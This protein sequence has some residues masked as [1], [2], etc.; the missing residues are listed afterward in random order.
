MQDENEDFKD[1]FEIE[2]VKPADIVV[3]DAPTEDG[4]SYDVEAARQNVHHLLQ[5]GTVALDE[6][7]SVARSSQSIAGFDAVT[8]ML[9]TLSNINK[10]LIVIQEKK[11]QMK[12]ADVTKGKPDKVVQNNLYVGS[13]DD[14]SKIVEEFEKKNNV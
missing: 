6:L 14:F 7:L 11:K 1:I 5:K 8:K 2:P 3:Y 4:D 12:I 13:T 10:D 9:T